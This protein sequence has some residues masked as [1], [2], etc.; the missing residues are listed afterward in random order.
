MFGSAE[1]IDFVAR[2]DCRK[3]ASFLLARRGKGTFPCRCLRI[4]KLAKGVSVI[5]DRASL[6]TA[7]DSGD[8]AG[9][10]SS[11]ESLGRRAPCIWLLEGKDIMGA[12]EQCRPPACR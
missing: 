10:R 9:M 4:D 2:I 12:R 5:A 7:Q 1:F 11:Q 6:S 3:I 8:L